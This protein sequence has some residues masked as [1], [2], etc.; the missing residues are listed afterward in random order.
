M[1]LWGI[2]IEKHEHKFGVVLM[3][4]FTSKT[5]IVVETKKTH[6]CGKGC[7]SSYLCKLT[8]FPF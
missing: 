8:F 5:I 6:Q 4:F 1:D 7:K 2:E 3:E